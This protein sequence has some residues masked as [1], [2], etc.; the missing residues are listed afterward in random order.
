[1][2]VVHNQFID[3]AAGGRAPYTWPINHEEEDELGRE[4][5]VEASANIAGT[6]TIQSQGDLGPMRFAFT[7]TILEQGQVNEM[8][9]WVKI[10]DSRTIHFIDFAEDRYEVVITAFKPKRVRV[11]LNSRQPDRPW[12]WT[13]RIEMT[14]VRVVSGSMAGAPA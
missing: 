10:C 8:W 7:G 13:Y 14:V 5:S 12:K 2:A 6:R 11:A 9:E 1:M 4:R 3:V